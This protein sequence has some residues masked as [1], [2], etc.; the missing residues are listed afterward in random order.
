[1]KKVLAIRT[2]DTRHWVGDGFPVRTLLSYNDEHV[3][4]MSPFLLVDYAGPAAFQPTDGRRGV[5]QH[6][7][8]GFETVTI[9]Y[10][11]EVAHRDSAGNARC[12]GHGADHR[13]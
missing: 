12:D 13:R 5:G 7:H 11:G 10:R 1:M 4:T 3:D 2:T 9:V 6:P 8:R